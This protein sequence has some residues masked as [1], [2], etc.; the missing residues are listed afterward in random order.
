M[1]SKNRKRQGGSVANYH[2]GILNVIARDDL[3]PEDVEAVCLEIIKPKSKPVLIASAYG[4][5]NSQIDFLDKIEILLQILDNEHKELIIV[6]DLNCDFLSNNLSNHTKRFNDIVNIF[7]LTQLIDQPTRITE[8]TA[9]LLD[10]ALVNN[11]E[12][13]SH[14]GVLHVGISDHS[15]IYV[16]RKMIPNLLSQEILKTTYREILTKTYTML[17]LI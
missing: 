7:Q 3:V 10:V 6:G 17:Y 14:S 1:V 9:S 12:K 13:I 2:R 11:P 15:L 4:P 5:P 8:K 16:C